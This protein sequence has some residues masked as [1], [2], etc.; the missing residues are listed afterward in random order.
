MADPAPPHVFVSYASTDHARVAALVA[1]LERAGVRAWLDRTGIPGGA[2]YGPEIV[3]AIR[4]SARATGLLLGRRLRL[5]Q[6]PPGGGLGMD[7]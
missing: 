5:A 3:A 1:A 6:R 4:E 7:A 2:T